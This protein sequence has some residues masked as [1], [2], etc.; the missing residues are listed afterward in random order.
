[1]LPGSMTY[2][3]GID[4]ADPTSDRLIRF[5]ILRM[6]VKALLGGGGGFGNTPQ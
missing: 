2:K 1:M 3:S 4:T 5:Q 6:F